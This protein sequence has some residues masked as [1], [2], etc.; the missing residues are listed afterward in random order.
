MK[1]IICFITLLMSNMLFAEIHHGHHHDKAV[2]TY[3]EIESLLESARAQRIEILQLS[4]T[5]KND[6]SVNFAK[7][8]EL[9]NRAIREVQAGLTCSECNRPKSIIEIQDDM[10]FE[11]HLYYA[12]AKRGGDKAKGYQKTENYF[13]S[14][15]HKAREY[16]ERINRAKKLRED[17]IWK[18][19][20]L[21]D[22][23]L[24]PSYSNSLNGILQEY[25][26]TREKTE[27]SMKTNSDII[28]ELD[29][30]LAIL[31]KSDPEYTEFLA[32][33][34]GAIKNMKQEI[35]V[36]NN[37]RL[38][39]NNKVESF[40]DQ[41]SGFNNAIKSIAWELGEEPELGTA[42]SFVG[43]SFNIPAF[44]IL[45]AQPI[46]RMPDEIDDFVD[47][48]TLGLINRWSRGL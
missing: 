22:T 1:T 2:S 8:E 40:Y 39:A 30:L 4:Y 35:E 12:E 46:Q 14:K 6:D 45:V 41:Y 38:K 23:L 37:L 9:Y 3:H 17:A 28:K 47:N 32:M 25:W 48:R 31:P 29:E 16:K 34:T 27:D 21:R 15:L 24:Y 19:F 42:G 26:L 33:I 13:A 10:S 44:Q 36:L 43:N 7:I 11:A 20:N 5:V 18:S